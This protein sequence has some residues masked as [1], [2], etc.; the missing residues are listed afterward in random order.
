MKCYLI[1]GIAGFIGSAIA[2]RLIRNGHKVVGVD[3]FM[4]GFAHNVPAEAEFFEFD[5]SEY[6]SF[7]RLSS[8]KFDAV[9]HLAAQ[10]SGEISYDNPSYDVLSNTMGTLNALRFAEAS[11]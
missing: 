7:E 2:R 9:L 10:S 8:F 1:T 4:T 6:A 3:N 5:I 11:G